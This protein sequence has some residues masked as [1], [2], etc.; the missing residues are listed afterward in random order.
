VPFPFER[1]LDVDSIPALYLG[2]VAVPF[3]L[4]WRGR[5]LAWT[6][7]AL[8]SVACLAQALRA[9]STVGLLDLEIYA[10]A[11]RAWAEGLSIYDYRHPTYG[12]GSTYPPS[13][14]VAFTP[15]TVVGPVLRALVWTAVNVV[16]LGLTCRIVATRLLGLRGERADTWALVATGLAAVT[17]P[18]WVSIAYQGQINVLLWLLVVADAGTVGRGSRWT[19]VGIGVAT[20]L[21]LVPGLFV[22]W[23]LTAGERRGA[24]RALATAGA[25]TAVGSLLAPGDSWDYWTDLVW[26]SSRVGRLD[27]WANNSLLGTLARL[28]KPGPTRTILWVVLALVVVGVGMWRARRATRSGD[29]LAATA[30]VGCASSL[31]SPISWSHHLGFLVLALAAAAGSH[32]RPPRWGLLV[33]GWI[34][35]LDPVGF[36]S[37]ATTSGLRTLA[38]LL[39]VLAL[40]VQAGRSVPV[41]DDGVAASRRRS[42]AVDR[43]RPARLAGSPPPPPGP[44]PVPRADAAGGVASG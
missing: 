5:R 8:A 25:V 13:A 1:L 35:L 12:L 2:L 29:L 10:G 19:G 43:S 20:A 44:R 15:L 30:I 6:V 26:D 23:L 42:P 16:A 40:P 38:L 27:D 34:F 22:L 37:D 33:A 39:V 7:A 3:L 9:Q 32:H 31:V 41:E 21:K 18:V 28:V 11:A 14:A 24:L 36:G 4:V 17:L